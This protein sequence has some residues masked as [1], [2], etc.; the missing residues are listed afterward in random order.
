MMFEILN[1]LDLILNVKDIVF[2][3]VYI[4]LF[5]IVIGCFNGGCGDLR[6]VFD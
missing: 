3:N 6:D 1:I 2:L 5:L 4:I